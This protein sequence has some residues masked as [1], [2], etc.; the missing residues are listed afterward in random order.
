MK[1]LDFRNILVRE[2]F[3]YV[4]PKGYLNH[5]VVWSGQHLPEP[6][7]RVKMLAV[8]QADF[9]RQY[10]TTG[11]KINDPY[12]YPD[13][14]KKDPETGEMCIQPITRCAFAFQRIIKTKQVVHLVGNDVQFELSGK[15]GTSRQEIEDNDTLLDFRQGWLDMDMETRFYEAVDSIKTVGD[16]AVVGYF[17]SDGKA[18]AKVLSF[19]D[20]DKLYPHYS[21]EPDRLEL[22]ARKYYDIDETGKAVREWV[23]VWDDT[24][25]YRARRGIS[26]SPVVQRI[27]EVFGLA[28]YTIVSQE[29]HGFNFCPVAYHRNREGACWINSQDTIE[30]YEEAYS[31][32]A[33]NNKANAF[34]VFYTKGNDVKLVGDMNGAVKAVSINDTDGDAGYLNQ[35]DVSASFNTMLKSLYDLIYEQSFAVKPPELKSGDLPGVAVK[36]LYSPAV[37]QA[38]HDSQRLSG[39]LRQLVRIVKYAYGWQ[40]GSPVSLLNLN[41]NSWI[42]PY[43]HQN[44]SE[45]FTNIA[46]AVQNGFLSKRTASERIPKYAKNDEVDRIIR[47]D[48]RKRRLDTQDKINLQHEQLK[49]E[50]EKAQAEAR[51]NRQQS[52]SD[53]NTGRT[54]V[55]T[56]DRNGNRPGENNWDEWNN[57]H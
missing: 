32:F 13:V 53:V 3:Y 31:Y 49:L 23:E 14:Y 33:E 54:R 44:D 38:I 37:E 43:V 34:P 42:E 26:S 24:Y 8:T 56:T 28:G 48:L 11:H 1:D 2:P 41:I 46:T 51:I 25:L 18:C 10:Y 36:L 45:M 47:E 15:A 5:A 20:G 9:L 52:G 29:R 57:T 50:I 21:S 55:R 4:L 16:A 6:E 27:K 7:D 35:G 40:I 39:F 12:F 17:D 22:F 19:L 30:A